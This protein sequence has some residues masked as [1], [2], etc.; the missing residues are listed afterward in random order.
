MAIIVK[1]YA[2]STLSA[3]IGTADT[4]IA[5]TSGAS[6]PTYS[7]IFPTAG[8]DY[9]F[10]VIEDAGNNIEIV[11]IINRAGDVVTV[12]RAQEGTTALNFQAGATFEIRATAQTVADLAQ[13]GVVTLAGAQTITGQKT[14]TQQILG[15]ATNATQL[16]GVA[17]ASYVARDGA[18]NV[19]IGTPPT[20]YRLDVRSPS[21]YALNLINTLATSN[22]D[23]ANPVRLTS[24]GE[25]WN[26]LHFNASRFAWQT[27]NTDRMTLSDVGALRVVSDQAFGYGENSGGTATQTTSKSTTVT[28]NKPT[29]QITMHNASMAAGAAVIFTLN[30]SLLTSASKLTVHPVGAWTNYFV[31]VLSVDTGLARIRVSNLHTGSLSDAI[32]LQFNVFAGSTT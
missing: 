32:T 22:D 8:Y 18:G 7:V 17:A 11:R 9:S 31:I 15:T 26:R 16:G 2:R 6:F 3:G 28:L 30:N 29:G 20:Y 21:I 27:Y 25:Y 19:G 23:A 14:F 10:A 4:T 1:N 13:S 24:Y 5:L 12:Q